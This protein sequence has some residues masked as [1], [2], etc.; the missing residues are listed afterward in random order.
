MTRSRP[1]NRTAPGRGR[2]R[3]RRDRLAA[4]G[5]VVLAVAAGLVAAYFA[6]PKAWE[7]P[8]PTPTS[9]APVPNQGSS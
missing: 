5:V 4:F 7:Q 6:S 9:N 1:T 8:T 3:R 2:R